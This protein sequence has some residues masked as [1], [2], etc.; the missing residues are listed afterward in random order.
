M[1][2]FLSKNLLAESGVALHYRDHDGGHIIRLAITSE[3]FFQS[4]FHL[5]FYDDQ[6]PASSKMDIIFSICSKNIFKAGNHAFFISNFSQFYE[7]SYMISVISIKIRTS[8][9]EIECF[10]VIN[11]YHE[12]IPKI[13][14]NTFFNPSS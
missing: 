14:F 13:I 10:D 11:L 12:I 3:W 6:S 5:S 1:L 8:T 7:M 4:V 9:E 2:I